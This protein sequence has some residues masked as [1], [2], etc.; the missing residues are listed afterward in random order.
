VV[1]GAGKD[2]P[3]D[4]LFSFVLEGASGLLFVGG[5]QGIALGHGIEGD[6][7]ASHAFFG[8]QRVIQS[9]QHMDG[10][11]EGLVHVE[12]CSREA[13]VVNGLIP[14]HLQQ[15]RSQIACDAASLRQLHRHTCWTPSEAQIRPSA[16]NLARKQY[17]LS[18]LAQRWKSPSDWVFSQVFHMPAARNAHDGLM[19]SDPPPAGACKLVAQPF[20][21]S[22]DEGVA[23]CVLWCSGP[24]SNW[25][26]QAITEA[27][28]FAVDRQGGG[29]F[30]WYENPKKS[31][32]NPH[33]YHVQVFW[34]MANASSTETQDPSTASRQ[35]MATEVGMHM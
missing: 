9:L 35:S 34:R 26:D 33:L 13:G 32:E 29:E 18:N 14:A 24:K 20:P 21:Y 6:A 15:L 23:H 16:A 11:D 27:I 1:R 8:T 2:V 19:C 25:T 17:F 12:G 22:V 3:C 5:W 28:S 7:V 30:V 31:I 10:W 4:A